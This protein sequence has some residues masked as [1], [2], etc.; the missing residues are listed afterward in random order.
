MHN[1]HWQK[2]NKHLPAQ[3]LQVIQQDNKTG[4]INSKLR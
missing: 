1:I 4:N 2:E 3:T